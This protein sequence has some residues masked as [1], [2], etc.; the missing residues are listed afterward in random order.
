MF[1]MSNSNDSKNIENI[2]EFDKMNLNDS[3]LRGIYAYGFEKPAPIQEKSIMQIISGK[4]IIAQSQSGTGKTGAFTISTLQRIDQSLQECQ[5]LII[6]PTRELT[7]QI[8]DVCKNI[9]Q[10]LKIRPVLA[11]GGSDIRKSKKE[12]EN[13]CSLVIGTPGR[14]IDMIN[15]RFLNTKYIKLIVLDEADEMLKTSFVVQIQKIVSEIP[16][17]SQIC[18]F[19]ATMPREVLDIT[20]HFMVNPHYILV[21]QEELTLEGIKQF[22]VDVEREEFKFDTFCDLYSMISISQ[23][24]VYVNKKRKA[25]KSMAKM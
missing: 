1:E 10:Y 4:D 7:C 18:L 5:A 25:E 2:D 3:L 19:S 22:Y 12:L 24:M 15:R 11:V 6:A 13:S 23:S 14:I 17:T 16:K 9:G 21:K 8:Y 20:T